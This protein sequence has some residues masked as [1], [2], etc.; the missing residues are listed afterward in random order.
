[1]EDLIKRASAAIKK[2]NPE[3]KQAEATQIEAESL[4]PD[5]WKD[6]I[7]ATNKMKRLAA[8]QDQIAKVKRLRDLIV[9]SNQKEI[10]KLLEEMETFLYFS[11]EFVNGS[12]IVSIHSGQGGVE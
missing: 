4:S 8:L 9:E 3:E 10:E 6:P 12:A 2:I 1:M 11:G 5:F 7:G